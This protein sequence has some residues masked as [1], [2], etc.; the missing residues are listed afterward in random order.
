MKTRWAILVACCA[1]MAGCSSPE[2]VR[3]RAGGPGG[4]VGNR[5]ADVIM[6]EGSDPFWETP[7]VIPVEHPSLEPAR[8]A[9]EFGTR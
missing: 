5:P 7:V 2:A 6:H 4:D 8:H 3:T 1:V 9:Q